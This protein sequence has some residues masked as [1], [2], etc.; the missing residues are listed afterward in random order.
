MK[1]VGVFLVLA[2]LLLLSTVEAQYTTLWQKKIGGTGGEALPAWFTASNNNVRCLAYY[3]G[4][5]YIVQRNSGATVN[6]VSAADGSDIST[7]NNGTGIVSGGTFLLNDVEV[8]SNGEIFACNLTTNASTSAFKVYRWTSEG[9]TP[10][11]VIS[12]TGITTRLGD[13]ITMVGS[14][15]DNSAVLYAASASTSTIIKFTT[16]DNGVSW[17]SSTITLSD[18]IMGSGPCVAPAGTGSAKFWVKSTGQNYKEY[19]NTGT[20]TATLPGGIVATG[21]T[22]VKYFE[23]SGNK[24]VVTAKFGATATDNG[25]NIA[26][27]TAGTASA[28]LY[29]SGPSLGTYNNSANGGDVAVKDSGNGTFVVFIVSPGN[30]FG[31]YQTTN[32][33]LPV[34]LA[35]FTAE[36]LGSRV[37]LKWNTSTENNNCGFEVQKNGG[38]YWATL[39]FVAGAG[40]SNAPQSYSYTD[41]AAAGKAV[42]RLKQIDRDGKF[43]YSK[44]VEAVITSAPSAAVLCQNYPNPFNPVTTIEYS[45]PATGFTSLKIYNTL[46]AEVATLVNGVIASGISHSVMFDAAR[47]PSG[48][49]FYTIRSG[50]YAETKKMFLAK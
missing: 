35:S 6:V 7:L 4:H 19:D 37:E 2:N 29:G 9:G 48:L 45:I 41:I 33:P 31:A 49:Y 38:T 17:T 16:A 24:F 46:G 1:K 8:S 3:S 22:S 23:S 13:Y 21:N 39:G 14:T 28:T 32:A 10:A 47:L 20:F 43:C 27:I 18:G 11:I 42:Y 5:I 40:T 36:I 25:L 44:E 15:A 34:E 50:S 12:Y 26:N 30:G